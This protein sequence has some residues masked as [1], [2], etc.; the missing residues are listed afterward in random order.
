VADATQQHPMW[1]MVTL[2]RFHFELGADFGEKVLQA[3]QL[4]THGQGVDITDNMDAAMLQGRR[5]V[6]DVEGI[7]MH[8]GGRLDSGH[9][10][11]LAKKDGQWVWF[12]DSSVLG[13]LAQDIASA[14]H[15]PSFDVAREA[16][17]LVLKL[18]VEDAHIVTGA[19]RADQEQTLYP[20]IDDADL[21]SWWIPPNQLEIDPEEWLARQ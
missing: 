11:T 9:Y 17:V 20:I 15:A 10:T 12:D 1:L 2:P 14:R 6:Y 21:E 18:R 7:V 5:A 16:Y 19:G 4:S 3:L 8:Q 13:V